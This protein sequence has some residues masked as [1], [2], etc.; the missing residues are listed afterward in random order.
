VLADTC[1]KR[2]ISIYPLRNRTVH[3][4]TTNTTNTTTGGLSSPQTRLNNI[5][6]A[7]ALLTKNRNI[8][9]RH[10]TIALLPPALR[11]PRL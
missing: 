11:L 6:I 2:G 8:N 10:A 3:A 7:P 9:K 4:I 1:K 5:A